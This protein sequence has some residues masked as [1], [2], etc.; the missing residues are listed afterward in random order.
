[1]RPPASSGTGI[2][3]LRR[4]EL[5]GASRTLTAAFD[6]DPL[7]RFLLPGDARRAAWLQAFHRSVLGECATL[8]GAYTLDEGPSAGAIGLILPGLW[9]VPFHRILRSV[10][11][12]FALPTWAFVHKGLHIEHRIRSLHPKTPHLYVYVLGVSP[13]RKR[14][15]LGARLMEHAIGIARAKRCPVHL[16]TANPVNLP[17]YRRFGLE[18][19]HEIV[20]HG[21]P[22]IWVM[23]SPAPG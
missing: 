3:P 9:P 7:F 21:G 18:V 13:T 12:P 23:A 10:V 2:R 4:D 16:E 5:V 22:P 14:Q 11:L 8:D 15:G 20:S 17:F 19:E 1:M 6:D